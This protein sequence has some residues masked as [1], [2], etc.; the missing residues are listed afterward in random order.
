[1]A[2]WS[3]GKPGKAGKGVRPEQTPA[4][5]PGRQSGGNALPGPTT[6]YGPQPLAVALALRLHLGTSLTS[7]AV[8]GRFRPGDRGS[9][10]HRGVD[11]GSPDLGVLQTF[12]G[13][14]AAARS[15]RL[16]TP[17][18]ASAGPAGNVAVLSSLAAMGRPDVQ[19][20]GGLR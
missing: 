9:A 5:R 18:G 3:L 16:G 20:Y 10:V 1:M 13:A 6:I 2:R 15:A 7:P 8:A 19:R 12:R 14:V 17:N 4:G 11:G